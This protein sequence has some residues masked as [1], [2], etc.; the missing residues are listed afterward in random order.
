MLKSIDQ[1]FISCIAVMFLEF[2]CILLISV[3]PT[4]GLYFAVLYG[5]LCLYIIYENIEITSDRI[6]NNLKHKDDRYE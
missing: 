2:G 6:V 4:Y 5:I 1:L 3:F